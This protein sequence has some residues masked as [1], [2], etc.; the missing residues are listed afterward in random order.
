MMRIVI[1]GASGFV[2][3]Y[4]TAHLEQ[5]GANV[6]PV[7]RSQC[8]GA[9]HVDDYKQS[10]TGEVLIHLAE[11]PDRSR[12]N[13]LG[14]QYKSESSSLVRLLSERPG[15]KMIYASS[16]VVYGNKN[17][18]PCG[19]DS[20]V[21]ATDT[22]SETKLLNEK[23]ALESGGA[24]VR[25]SNLFGIG[26][27]TNNV[28]TDILNQIPGDGAVKVRDDK[29]VCDFLHVTDAVSAFDLLVDSNYCG[30]LNVGSGIGTS[31]RELAKILLVAAN[32]K[33][34][35]ITATQPSSVNSINILDISETNKVLGWCQGLS[36]SDHLGQL[37]SSMG[38]N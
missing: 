21:F 17:E 24:V 16:G 26:M 31:I 2:G 32:Q 18:F 6:I 28:I 20:P 10:P 27:A 22:Y 4:L 5:R 12:V 33:E 36:L 30:I 38:E 19:L 14:E 7:S 25:L 37:M 23:I 9:Q 29:P 34:R 13:S 15:Q 1:T 3:R 11:D 8:P 35:K